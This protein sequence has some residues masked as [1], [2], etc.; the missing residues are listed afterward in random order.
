MRILWRISIKEDVVEGISCL[1]SGKFGDEIN[2]AEEARKRFAEIQAL[3]VNLLGLDFHC[4]SGHQGIESEAYNRAITLA[5]TCMLEAKKFG[6]DMTILDI[7]GG[8][9]S[10]DISE[11]TV[12]YLS[13]LREYSND[14]MF[15]YKSLAEPGRHFCSQMF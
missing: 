10:G 8:F 4:G 14:K 5:N 9:P 3:G 1:F 2:T 13:R 7:G 6:H 11:Q 12:K 15:G